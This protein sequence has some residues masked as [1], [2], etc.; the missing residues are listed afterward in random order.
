MLIILETRPIDI[1][2]LLEL[3]KKG[4]S[5]TDI[6]AEG[7][8]ALDLAE[9]TNNDDVINAIEHPPEPNDGTVMSAVAEWIISLPLYIS[10]IIQTTWVGLVG[11]SP[12]R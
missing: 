9:M 10:F 5:L 11:A 3:R 12:V 8:T 2:S 7:K 6:N 4:A 1:E